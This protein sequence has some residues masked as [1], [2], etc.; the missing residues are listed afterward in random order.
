[1]ERLSTILLLLVALLVSVAP[2]S[3]F[4]PALNTPRRSSFILSAIN[5]EPPS[6]TTPSTERGVVTQGNDNANIESFLQE[7]SSEI[8]AL[9]SIARM[10][11]KSAFDIDTKTSLFYFGVDLVAV[12]SSLSFLNAVIHSDFYQHDASLPLQALMVAPLQVLCGFAIWCMWC[13][14][15][16]AGHGTISKTNWINQLVGEVAHSMCCLTPFQPWQRSHLRHHLNH[17]HLTKDY[18]HQWF[19][20]EE[21]DELHPIFQASYKTRNVQ[22]PFLYLVYLLAG[23]PDGGHV[24]FY[25]KLWKNS[26]LENKMRGAL[27]VA[28]SMAT[29]GTLWYNMGTADFALVC[30]APWLIMSFW[31]FMVTYLQHHSEDGKLY[32]DDTWDFTKGAFETVDRNYGKW[33]NRMSHHMMDGHVVHHLFFTKVPHYRLEEATV[34]LKAGLEA[35]G[36]HHLYKN[37]DTPDFSQEIVKQFD[38]NWFFIDEAQV[39]RK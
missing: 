24:V 31:L 8:P 7:K 37:K 9:G 21:K 25:G 6:A 17:N 34:A 4:L 11:P 5:I 35:E 20:R 33:V 1:M 15:H 36:L 23:V 32:T 13:I 28:V 12:I 2:A 14:G 19:I 27:S 18:S 39:V 26:S 3:A 30:F 22:L 38:E 29:A 16:D 10:L